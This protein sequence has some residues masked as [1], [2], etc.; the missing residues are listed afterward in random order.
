MHQILTM[1]L[2]KVKSNPMIHEIILSLTENSQK[3]SQQDFLLV[4]TNKK[5]QKQN[6]N[7]VAFNTK[8]KEVVRYE[9]WQKTYNIQK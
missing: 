8:I 5:K 7:Q 4:T 3:L 2:Y 9:I 1:Q 6:V